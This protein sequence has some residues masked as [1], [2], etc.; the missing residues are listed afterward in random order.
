MKAPLSLLR[1]FAPDLPSARDL[2]SVM[3]VAG[4][5]VDS[6][7]AAAP[8][9]SQVVVGR[10]L[11]AE[12]IKGSRK[13]SL[14]QVALSDAKHAKTAAI[15]CG[16]DNI[17]TGALYPVAL[18]G[19]TLPQGFL[20]GRRKMAGVESEGMICSESEL[21][22]GTDSD[23]IM[24]LPD[25][26]QPGIDLR[27][28]LD[29]DDEILH[30]DITP[31]RADCF[32][33]E[34][35]ARDAAALLGL[36]FHPWK[37]SA[38]S[39][40]QLTPTSEDDAQLS[41]QSE[42]A[43][44]C[45]RY[46][47]AVIQNCQPGQSSPYWLRELLR[48]MGHNSI[49]AAVDITNYV[50]LEL[51]QPLHAFDFDRVQ[52]G[53]CIRKP[54]QNETLKLLNGT[55]YTLHPEDLLIADHHKPLALA[56]VMG[57][58]DSG[59]QPESRS[60]LLESAWFK[61]SMIAATSMRYHL[62]SEASRRFE[63]G[64][65]RQLQQRAL[66]RA[67]GLCADI[68]GSTPTHRGHYSNDSAFPTFPPIHLHDN[69]LRRIL[70]TKPDQKKLTAG[71]KRLELQPVRKD[72]GWQVQPP[73]H[74]FDLNIAED[75]AEEAAR[76]IGYDQLPSAP[77]VTTTAATEA[78]DSAVQTRQ[79]A[80]GHI[81]Q[82]LVAQG[83]SEIL[84]YSFIDPALQKEL[85]PSARPQEI[86]ALASPLASTQ[87]EM[88]ISLI[89]G[90]LQAA[91]H[92]LAHQ[93]ERIRLFELGHC[94]RRTLSEPSELSQPK[95]LAGLML[96][97]RH[98]RSWAW[99]Q[100]DAFDFYDAKAVLE[101]LLSVRL[102]YRSPSHISEL[103]EWLTHWLQHPQDSDSCHDANLHPG[104]C[105]L[106]LAHPE[107]HASPQALGWVGRL[108]PDKMPL[109]G[110]TKHPAIC[111]EIHLDALPSLA[112]SSVRPGP[113][114]F[115]KFDRLP[116]IKRDLSLKVPWETTAATLIQLASEAAG[117]ELLNCQI[118]DV[119]IPP[120]PSFRYLALNLEWQPIENS[121]TSTQIDQKVGRILKHLQQHQIQLRT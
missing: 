44:G 106:I 11:S 66:I 80:Y 10:I 114:R 121:W 56:G 24:R 13:L 41:I 68:L 20:I 90:L 110:G 75:V 88:R 22:I 85:I 71:F 53:I 26:L 92:N 81:R 118:F 84:S 109:L 29:L 42:Y 116:R 27:K 14:C 52:G 49:N 5:E 111:F 28:A 15:V 48:R 40:K 86:L 117:S 6:I 73:A 98:P 87:S 63:R 104:Q 35:L 93:Y 64:V 83:F 74:R 37:P 61:P 9:F 65:S 1:T 107:A 33:L 39:T 18:P 62:I 103:P 55:D 95:H 31:N 23:G 25:H 2:A 105:A 77:S 79:Q 43:S 101:K 69:K 30:F 82:N 36:K 91:A 76:L 54:H 78:Q 120:E 7:E 112:T 58:M 51:G 99:Q 16:A 21:G 50:M 57:G 119:H 17:E 72:S 113:V 32:S 70:G 89:P 115:K 38:R 102:S 4:L 46:L 8:D 97:N 12:A 67:L 3:T 34:G 59:I 19:S 100:Q 108:H 60:I 45:P 96:G 47:G 94:F